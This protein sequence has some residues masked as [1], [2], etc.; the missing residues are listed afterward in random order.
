MSEFKKGIDQI[1]RY[2]DTGS[3]GTFAI[4]VVRNKK[5]MKNQ[6]NFWARQN[7]RFILLLDDN[8]LKNLLDENVEQHPFLYKLFRRNENEMA[9]KQ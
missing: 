1:C 2:T 5:E 4:F 3:F 9:I 6:Q 8:D 7:D